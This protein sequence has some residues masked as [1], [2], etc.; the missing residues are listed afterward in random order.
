M[1][2]LILSAIQDAFRPYL[3]QV[4][5]Q[6]PEAQHAYLQSQ[7]AAHMARNARLRDVSP[8]EIPGFFYMPA[9]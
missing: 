5:A 7:F 8:G 9:I 4:L 1:R 2:N 6:N 3:A